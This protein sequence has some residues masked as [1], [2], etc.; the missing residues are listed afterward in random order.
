MSDGGR[1]LLP[2]RD[3]SREPAPRPMA[4]VASGPGRQDALWTQDA[5]EDAVMELTPVPQPAR[6]PVGDQAGNTFGEQ[7]KG[8][9]CSGG[10][11]SRPAGPSLGESLH[12]HLLC[13]H[14]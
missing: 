13:V 6:T 14:R 12:P 4:G 11:S 3:E 8:L 7:W 2:N 10:D 9:R 1:K 5:V